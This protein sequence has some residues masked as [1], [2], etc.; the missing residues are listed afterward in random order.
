MIRSSMWRPLAATCISILG[1]ALYACAAPAA[2]SN[3]SE[4][5]ST[6]G[7][8][9][10]IQFPKMYS[11]F[12]P[13]HEAKVPAIVSGVSKV[14]W[15][16]S[17]PEVA[18]IET[19][20]DGSAM[21]TVRKAG[22][23][24]IK[25]KAGSL[26]GEAPLTI[27]EAKDGEWEA[28]N[29]RYN[30]GVVLKRGNRPDGGWEAGGGNGG[31]TPDPERQQASCTNCHGSGGGDDSH[32]VQHTPMQT[33]GYTDAELVAIFTKGKKPAGV[34]QRVMSADRWNRIHQW[35]MD[36]FAVKG[37]VVYLRTLEPRTQGTVDFGGRGP[38]GD[39]K[40]KGKGGGK[41]GGTGTGTGTGADDAAD[42]GAEPQ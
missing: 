3:S 35:S 42:S 19:Q 4:S 2:D 6:E 34:E 21:I 14:K 36:E 30:N 41:G 9:L 29:Q 5:A 33:A 20:A 31:G 16:V 27:T 38:K 10:E 1:A 37:L 11:T 40:G 17:D 7:E 32:D 28:G 13:E 18:D 39:G 25:A 15:S 23:V 24:T 22:T 26:T 8:A 12:D